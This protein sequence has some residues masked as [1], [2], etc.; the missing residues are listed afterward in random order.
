MVTGNHFENQLGTAIN[1]LGYY[2]T[3]TGNHIKLKTNGT[4]YAGDANAFPN[5][6]VG[7][8]GIPRSYEGSVSLAFNDSGGA[9]NTKSVV[10]RKAAVTASYITNPSA[11]TDSIAGVV[12]VAGASVADQAW[13]TI[14]QSGRADALF[15]DDDAATVGMPLC[16]SAADI[17]VL[18][19]AD[20]SGD[21]VVAIAEETSVGNG[22]DQGL[23]V[24]V[25]PP[26]ERYSI[27]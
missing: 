25:L 4:P 22:G 21:L 26:G 18:T 9:I 14:V 1:N 23:N 6:I 11:R 20:T 8:F 3:F 17:G 10:I 19:Y 16:V 13:C 15:D 27:P 2:W 12:F 5:T 7:N 24:T